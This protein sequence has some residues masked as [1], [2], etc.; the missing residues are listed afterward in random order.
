[1]PPPV[2]GTTT[3]AQYEAVFRALINSD[4]CGPPSVGVSGTTVLTSELESMASPSY[5]SNGMAVPSVYIQGMGHSIADVETGALPPA[6]VQKM[7]S[8]LTHSN[9]MDLPSANVTYRISSHAENENIASSTEAEFMANLCDEA[10]SWVPPT[11]EAEDTCDLFPDLATHMEVPF[12]GVADMSQPSFEH[13][14]AALSTERERETIVHESSKPKPPPNSPPQPPAAP[15]N[16]PSASY[17]LEAFNGLECNESNKILL[18][19]DE[20]QHG[21]ASQTF[22]CPELPPAA[23]YSDLVRDETNIVEANINRR[24]VLSAHHTFGAVTGHILSN[25]KGMRQNLVPFLIPQYRLK[26]TV[27]K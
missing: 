15:P 23:S 17:I 22:T 11:N 5:Q 24:H 16:S 25:C 2:E 6:E 9:G 8:I 14:L 27:L 13:E 10:D 18:L 19:H 20:P 7:T 12:P 21:S 3:N 4:M 1:V 26:L